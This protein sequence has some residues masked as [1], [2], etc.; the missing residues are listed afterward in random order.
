MSLNRHTE[1][2]KQTGCI[3]MHS[4]PLETRKTHFVNYE[5]RIRMNQSRFILFK[6][7][8]SGCLSQTGFLDARSEA[9]QTESRISE[10][11]LGTLPQGL[12][13]KE[14]I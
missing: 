1:S 8:T 10:L 9:M 11:F 7:P 12:L 5:S 6:I 13:E 2:Q 3:P 14:S 4:R